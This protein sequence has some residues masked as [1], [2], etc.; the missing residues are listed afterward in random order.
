MGYNTIAAPP[1]VRT[2]HTISS[3]GDARRRPHTGADSISRSKAMIL[4]LSA[5]A[6]YCDSPARRRAACLRDMT[7]LSHF[8]A[9]KCGQGSACASSMPRRNRTAPRLYICGQRRLPPPRHR[10][11]YRMRLAR[12]TIWGALARGAL[13]RAAAVPARRARAE[14]YD[15]KA[16]LH[17]LS[18]I[19][20][21]TPACSSSS[22]AAHID[23]ASMY[24]RQA[25]RAAPS[26]LPPLIGGHG[27]ASFFIPG[28]RHGLDAYA[29]RADAFPCCRAEGPITEILIAI[30]ARV[31]VGKMFLAESITLLRSVIRSCNSFHCGAH[32]HTPPPAA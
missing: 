31:C 12:R 8:R 29:R 14:R 5:D 20:L 24:A 21:M 25:S 15:A 32:C 17:F 18:A 1:P 6:R 9:I 7:L 23:G 30:A 27:A 11:G 13:E 28:R 4:M 22:L 19:R 16:R 10:R 2:H 26:F 3:K